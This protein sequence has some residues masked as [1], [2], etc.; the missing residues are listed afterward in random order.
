MPSHAGGLIQEFGKEDW[1]LLWE[2]KNPASYRVF[3]PVPA[4]PAFE[5]WEG[6][7]SPTCRQLWSPKVTGEAGGGQKSSVSA[8]F[9]LTVGEFVALLSMV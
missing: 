4:H 6:G 2:Q 8:S 5:S 3:P 1:V 9:L 7:M